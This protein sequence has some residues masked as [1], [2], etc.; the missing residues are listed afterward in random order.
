MRAHV[1]EG[2]HVCVCECVYMCVYMHMS[3]CVCDRE[4]EREY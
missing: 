4:G 3:V 1:C 2:I